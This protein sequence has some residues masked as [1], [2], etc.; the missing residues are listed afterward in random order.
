[1]KTKFLK[2]FLLL[3]L[4]FSGC[5]FNSLG[6]K[7]IVEAQAAINNQAF[8]KAEKKILSA[9]RFDLSNKL[10]IKALH[11]LG[12]I[13]A[14]HLDDL[15]GALEVFIKTLEIAKDKDTKKKSK[16]YLANLYFEKLRNYEKSSPLYRDLFSSE[17]NNEL[18]VQYYSRYIRSIYEQHNFKLVLLETKNIELNEDNLEPM[19]L[20]ALSFYFIGNEK[21][22][23]DI[24][25][26]LERFS[27][28]KV[29]LLIE[30]K[31]FKALILENG[32]YLRKSYGEYV[33]LF[34]FFPN[35]DLIKRRIKELIKRKKNIKR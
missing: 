9:L 23:L 27:K 3:T 11:Q 13:R 8:K 4:F 21:K 32:E 2:F 17:K 20:K 10:K 12:V 29:N 28:I 15:D 14:F 1:M 18:K 24:L 22:S 35:S 30:V 25:S 7:E 19:M 33:E 16:V 31:L 5:H 34:K 6:H 26:N